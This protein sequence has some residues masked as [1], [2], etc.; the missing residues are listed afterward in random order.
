MLSS[1][2]ITGPLAYRIADNMRECRRGG[3]LDR[4][5]QMRCTPAITA[6]EPFDRLRLTRFCQCLGPAVLERNRKVAVPHGFRRHERPQIIDM[7]MFGFPPTA[8]PQDAGAHSP[9]TERAADIDIV[10]RP[11]AQP[12]PASDLRM[13]SCLASQKQGVCAGFRFH[14]T[15]TQIEHFNFFRVTYFAQFEFQGR[16]STG[17]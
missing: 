9:G 4:K 17:Y 12:A 1:I 8:M 2:R 16:N 13:R 10:A 14:L 6:P 11:N 15:F 3:R 7:P 5:K